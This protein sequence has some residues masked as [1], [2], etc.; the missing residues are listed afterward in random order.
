[1]QLE[2]FYLSI[3]RTNEHISSCSSNFRIMPLHGY[4][5]GTLVAYITVD[6]MINVIQHKQAC[7]TALISKLDSI[8]TLSIS[9]FYSKQHKRQIAKFYIN[10]KRYF[11]SMKVKGKDE[12]LIA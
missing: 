2:L 8:K 11:L 1:M 3:L 9:T 12:V 4:L 5:I 6:I 7:S 10:F